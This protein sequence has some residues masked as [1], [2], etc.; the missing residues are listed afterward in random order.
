MRNPNLV[1]KRVILF[2]TLISIG[3]SNSYGWFI[4]RGVLP[5]RGGYSQLNTSNSLLALLSSIENCGNV[6]E[7]Y[8]ICENI[9]AIKICKDKQIRISLAETYDGILA[10]RAI[11]RI[12]NLSVNNL[13]SSREAI[14]IEDIESDRRYSQLTDC[15][16]V[17]V[18]SLSISD[19]SRY[20]WSISVLGIGEESQINDV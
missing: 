1:F 8:Q 5:I 6:D 17:C 14:V 10:V 9:P 16:D 7:L 2:L 15:V 19:L 12:A 13:H 4:S 11:Q 20:L 3:H 18:N